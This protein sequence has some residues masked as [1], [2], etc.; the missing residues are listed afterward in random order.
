MLNTVRDGLS[1]LIDID[2]SIGI[3]SIEINSF[4]KEIGTDWLDFGRVDTEQIP[5][6]RLCD[7]DSNEECDDN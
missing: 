4:A 5:L 1:G 2:I 6:Q 7:I 3:A